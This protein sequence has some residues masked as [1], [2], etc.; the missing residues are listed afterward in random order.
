MRA[1]G[2]KS[3]ASFRRAI[4]AKALE[5]P[6]FQMQGR[7]GQF[8]LSKDVAKWLIEQRNR[9]EPDAVK[10]AKSSPAKGDASQ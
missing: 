10:P 9:G 2:F 5:L 3:G 7:R 6:T 4:D 1:L 8:G